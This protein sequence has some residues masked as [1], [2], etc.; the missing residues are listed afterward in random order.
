M[1]QIVNL[2]E[3]LALPA[4]TI[5]CYYEPEYVRGLYRKGETLH[6]GDFFM[7]DLLPDY[8]EENSEWGVSLDERRWGEFN[9][10]QLFLVL[11]GVDIDMIIQGLLGEE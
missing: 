8:L 9:D 11:D 4:G 5:F 7:A 2:N 10:S 3:F 6:Y 1:S